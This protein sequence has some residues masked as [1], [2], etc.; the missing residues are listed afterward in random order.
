MQMIEVIRYWLVQGRQLGID[1][2]VMVAGVGLV[3]ASGRYPHIDEAKANGGILRNHRT[4]LKPDEMNL[5]VG[6][7]WLSD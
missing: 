6:W 1:Q 7:R 2:E 4:I 5:G 3:D